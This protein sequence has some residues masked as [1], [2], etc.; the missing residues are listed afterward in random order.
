[1]PAT[2]DRIVA[3]ISHLPHLLAYGLADSAGRSVSNDWVELIAG[4]FRDGT[5]VALSNPS[6]W[7]EILL[8]NRIEA[9]DALD[10]F[11]PWSAQVGAALRA[12]DREA[13]TRLLNEAHQAR[14]R[15]PR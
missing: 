1:D 12:N 2:H 11:N 8:E 15:F 3:A 6:R 5:R 9:A 7:T 4:S 14:K 10:I 13:L